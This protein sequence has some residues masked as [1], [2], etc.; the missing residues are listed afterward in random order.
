MIIFLNN[1]HS[2]VS[3]G[4]KLRRTAQVVVDENDDPSHAIGPLPGVGWYVQY[5]NFPGVCKLLAVK[6]ALH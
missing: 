6:R 1:Q 5:A 2:V 4:N 3:V